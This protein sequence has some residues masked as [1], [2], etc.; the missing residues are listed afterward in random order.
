MKII[1]NTDPAGWWYAIEDGYEPG[2][3]EGWGKTEQDA[4]D[5]LHEELETRAERAEARR[6]DRL[7]RRITSDEV[8]ATVAADVD[9]WMRSEPVVR[10]HQRDAARGA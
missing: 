9:A 2:S 7:A 5:A 8:A 10:Q 3:A 1:T 4:I 6:A